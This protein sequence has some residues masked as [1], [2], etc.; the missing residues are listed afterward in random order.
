MHCNLVD[1]A[2]KQDREVAGEGFV[3]DVLA[4]H[5]YEIL[6]LIKADSAAIGSKAA[7]YD[8]RKA[9]LGFLKYLGA[10]VVAN[11]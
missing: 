4:I 1:L 7:L 2:V 6:N 8:S 11:V 10:G 3:N 9:L 5:G